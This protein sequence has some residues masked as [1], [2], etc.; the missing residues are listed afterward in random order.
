MPSASL[1]D[2]AVLRI[3]GGDARTLLQGLVTCNM[4]HVTRTQAGFGALLTPQG[5]ILFDFLIAEDAQGFLLDTAASQSEALAKRLAMYRLRANVTMTPEPSLGVM[6]AWDGTPLPGFVFDDPRHHDLGRRAIVAK[7]EAQGDA[8]ADAYH[9][10]R[11]ICGVP[12]AG[13]DFSFNDIFP[14]DA[15]MD[16]IHGLDFKKGCYVGQEVVSRMEHRGGVRKRILPVTLR[17]PAP[18]PGTPILVGEVAIG[19][20]GTSAPAGQETTLA[21]A[22]IRTDRAEEALSAGQK[23]IAGDALVELKPELLS[24][25]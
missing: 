21:L 4:D 25:G 7:T 22:L 9:A 24:K 11:V 8:S 5:K 17:G 16:L 10:H 2:R 1:D 13:R 12:E 23:L 14:H 3:A 20:M 18:A 15:D 19:T 6:A